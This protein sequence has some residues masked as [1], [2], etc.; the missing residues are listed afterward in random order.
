MSRE[1]VVLRLFGDGSDEVKTLGGG[2][3]LGDLLRRPLAGTPI[4]GPTLIDHKVHRPHRLLDGRGRVRAMAIQDIDIIHIQALERSFGAFD[5]VLPG[6]APVVGAWAA[7]EE[8]GGD[9]EVGA[10]PTELAEG[11]AHDLLSAAIG[12]D[13]GVVEEVDAMVAAALEEGLGLLHVQLVAEAHPRTVGKLAHLETRPAEVVVLHLSPET[14]SFSGG[15][16]RRGRLPVVA[17]DVGRRSA[18]VGKKGEKDLVS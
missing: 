13:L 9:D 15:F 17:G 2:P 3:R 10:L 4:E 16:R 6:E 7:P 8:L 14:G 12:V 1:E 11:L 18:A 5:D